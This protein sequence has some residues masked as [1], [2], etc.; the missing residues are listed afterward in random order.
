MFSATLEYRKN[1]NYAMV[2]SDRGKEEEAVDFSNV[3]PIRS[4]ALGVCK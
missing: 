4:S 1:V 2:G 3:A